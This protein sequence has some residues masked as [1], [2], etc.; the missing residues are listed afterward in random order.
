MLCVSLVPLA[1]TFI[2]YMLICF[3]DLTI[4]FFSC[5]IGLITNTIS[6]YCLKCGSFGVHHVSV[7]VIPDHGLT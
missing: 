5:I 1:L 3:F 6:G 2:N 7:G 4:Q